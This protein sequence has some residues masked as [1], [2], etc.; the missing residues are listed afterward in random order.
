[1]FSLLFNASLHKKEG[2]PFLE[3]L[4]DSYPF[5]SQFMS[6]QWYCYI[7]LV[8][9]SF[10]LPVGIVGNIAALMAFS[11][12]RKTAT[13]GTVFL[14][15]LALCDTAW[16]LILP[17]NIYFTLQRPY[18]RGIHTFCQLKKMSFNVNIYGSIFFLTLVS[19]DRYV[20]TVHPIRSLGWWDVGRARL[21]S[22]TTWALLLLGSIPDLFVTFGVRRPG[23][24]TVCMDHIQGPFEY[25]KTIS[26]VRT[27][28]GFVLPFGAML[29]FYAETVRAIWGLPGRRGGDPKRGRSVTGKPL[30]LITAALL[31]FMV[32]FVPY[33]IMIV[34]LVFLRVRGLVTSANTGV[35]YAAY[36][37]L[38]AMC[39]VSSCLDPVLY[40]LASERFQKRLQRLGRG[41]SARG[42]EERGGG[43][44]GP[45]IG[46]CS[47]ASRRV[48]VEG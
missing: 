3:F 30:L 18:L 10:A 6:G 36:E 29:G 11:C 27:L 28:V 8:L 15:N 24:V 12:F 23:N 48:G 14:L 39:S 40:I 17:F 4:N 42:G 16:L 44:R 35:L 47:R 37:F 46:L 7:L 5:C 43:G 2:E 22:G 25:V 26:L 21:L 45:P 9:F 1:M 33:H 41:R 13:P 38:E 19:F 32:S 31:V 34:A 20:G